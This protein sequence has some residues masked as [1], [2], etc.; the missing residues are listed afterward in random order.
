[1][2]IPRTPS[3][4][5]LENRPMNELSHEEMAE[6]VLQLKVRDSNYLLIHNYSLTMV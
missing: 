5:P 3:P 2:I 1:M 6:L 4:V